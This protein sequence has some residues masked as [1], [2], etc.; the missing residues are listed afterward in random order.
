MAPTGAM[1]SESRPANAAASLSRSANSIQRRAM[2]RQQV[3]G[4]V[5][6][7][8]RRAGGRAGMLGSDRQRCQQVAQRLDGVVHETDGDVGQDLRLGVG[9]V[10]P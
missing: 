1:A 7:L 8:E 2:V 3:V 5:E 9:F 10:D 4:L 6:Q